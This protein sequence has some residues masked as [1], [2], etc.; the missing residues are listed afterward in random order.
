MDILGLDRLL[1]L[2]GGGFVRLDEVNVVVEGV[3]VLG[4]LAGEHLMEIGFKWL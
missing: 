4:G 2:R 3:G 1:L